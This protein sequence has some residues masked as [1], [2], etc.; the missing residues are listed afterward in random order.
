MFITLFKKI[1]ELFEKR[2]FLLYI[3][4]II[5]IFC[6]SI[7]YAN[8]YIEKFSYQFNDHNEL[9]LKLVPF[10]YGGIIDNLYHHNRFEQIWNGIDTYLSRLPFLP[11]FITLLCKI[12][13]NGYFIITAK[14]IIFF[15]LIFY[16]IYL[17]SNSSNRKLLSIIFLLSLFFYNFYNL[18]VLLTYGFADTYIAAILPCIFLILI[19]NLEKKYLLVSIL[20]FI[21]FFTKTTVF[22]LTIFIS[23]FFLIL[24]NKFSIYKRAFPIIF[25]SLAILFWGTFGVIKTQKFPIGSSMLSN[26]QEALAVAMNKNFKRYYP[27][28]SVDLIPEALAF[29]NVDKK[30]DNEWK[31]SNYFKNKNKEYIKNNKLNI[32]KDTITKLKFIFFNFR[33][34]AIHAEVNSNYKNPVMYSHIINRIIFLMSLV[35]LIK[36]L[37]NNLLNKK[38]KNIDIYYLIIVMFSLFP[39]VVGWATSKHLVPLF[40][41]ANFYLVFR[42]KYFKRL[43]Q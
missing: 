11:F 12:S 17:V 18:T 5:F 39:H 14:N 23:L 9:I 35:L 15:S 32:F 27:K 16:C 33:K 30:F 29:E 6:V 3:L 22:F 1:T 10:G 8:F 40:L 28:L 43:I 36:N 34:D 25:L 7:T 37:Y 13:L 38:I 20:I 26:N 31:F 19:S 41:V 4:F 42:L 24:E 2:L 21:L